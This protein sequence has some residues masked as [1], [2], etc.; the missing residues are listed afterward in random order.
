V[1]RKGVTL[2]ANS[3]PL[4]LHVPSLAGVMSAACGSTEGSGFVAGRVYTGT[5]ATLPAGLRVVAE[6]TARDTTG[7][8]GPAR[9]AW[10][11]T[12]VSDN[13]A[14]RLCGLP[15]G[16]AI[17]LRTESDS[18][19]AFGSAPLAVELPVARRFARADLVLD[20]TI[21]AVSSFS[22]TVVAD[23][24]GVPI[25]NAE[26]SITDIGRTVLTNRRGSFRVSGIPVGMHMVTVKRVGFAPMIT[27]STSVSIAPSTST[28]CSSL[29]PQ[30]S[31]LLK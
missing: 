7:A 19:S 1:S 20:T 6:W 22:G 24:S 3:A 26:V 18:G 30:P 16:V 25:E 14:Y 11:H 21:A 31:P 15:A 27:P 12:P 29:R 2:S 10:L 5:A 23:T 17:A 4:S 28:C 9:N 13:G 8:S